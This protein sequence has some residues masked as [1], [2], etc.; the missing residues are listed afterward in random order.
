ME[1][2]TE[3]DLLGK[4]LR[5]E[6]IRHRRLKEIRTIST[7][8]LIFSSAAF[9][10][11]TAIPSNQLNILQQLTYLSLLLSLIFNGL[12]AATA[13]WMD[14]YTNPYPLHPNSMFQKPLS[15][16]GYCGFIPLTW[17]IFLMAWN[18]S[19]LF[20]FAAIIS[21]FVSVRF[22]TKLHTVFH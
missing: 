9:I 21:V 15:L 7:A 18:I 20:C 19:W 6:S 11:L 16:Y 14:L 3:Y 12:F 10:Q 4:L 17:A 2:S 22:Y 1:S 5:S 8:A 13:M